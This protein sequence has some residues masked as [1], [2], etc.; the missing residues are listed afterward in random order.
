MSELLMKYVR[1]AVVFLFY[2]STVAVPL[3]MKDSYFSLIE[4]KAGIYLHCAVPAVFTAGIV[5][6][7]FLCQKIG[8]EK[9]LL[10]FRP[11]ISDLLLWA[12]LVWSLIATLASTS[13]SASF[14]G[15]IGWAMGSLMSAT[16]ILSTI[17][18]RRYFHFSV[19]MMIPVM[20]SNTAIFIIAICQ[21]AGRDVFGL[22]QRLD[23]RDFYAYLSTIGQ[24][25]SFSGYLCLSLP[26]MWGFFAACRDRLS[27]FIYGAVSFLGFLC[28]IL[29]DSDS[30]Y[31]GAG[32]CVMAML[33]FFMRNGEKIRRAGILL[34]LYGA[35]LLTVGQLP[36]FAGKLSSMKG[37]SALVCSF[38]FAFAV[39]LAGIGLTAL[40]ILVHKKEQKGK[41]AAG[42]LRAAAAVLEILLVLAVIIFIFYTIQNFDDKWGTGRGR[43]WRMGWEYFLQLPWSRRLTGIG[44]EMLTLIYVELRASMGVNVTA[45]HSEPL[46]I[47]LTQGLIGF[48]LY[49]LFWAYLARQYIQ[50]RLWREDGAV[51]F[52]PLAAYFGQSLFCSVYPVTGVLFCVSAALYLQQISGEK[53]GRKNKDGCPGPSRLRK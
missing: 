10:L 36:V 1:F 31:A 17:L 22:L 37:I 18:L 46:Q 26:L 43:I 45:A 24:K 5:L 9:K 32:I 35:G 44:Q 25:N 13:R 2:L 12:I 39:C 20:L 21:S 29:C 42:I 6:V 50:K 28:I 23:R 48:I 30:V 40:G 33:P 51:F 14:Y 52:F 47:L 27:E 4:A 7:F 3:Y 34:L 19:N 16:L 11:D 8:N 15:T 49:L 38:P 41:G 53:G